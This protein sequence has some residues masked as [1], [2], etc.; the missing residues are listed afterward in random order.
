MYDQIDIA[1]W[2]Q[3]M[4][5]QLQIDR[6]I[7]TQGLKYAPVF[8]LPWIILPIVKFRS[9]FMRL[10]Y[11]YLE[12]YFIVTGTK[13]NHAQGSAKIVSLSLTWFHVNPNMHN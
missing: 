4:T 8:A 13:R 6:G 3:L 10:F 11:S 5:I 2:Y 1:K 9:E 7:M 12:G